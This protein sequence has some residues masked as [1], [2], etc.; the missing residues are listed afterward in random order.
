[1]V[2]EFFVKLES[3]YKYKLLLL[4]IPI[5]KLPEINSKELIRKLFSFG[6]E[7]TIRIKGGGEHTFIY[8]SIINNIQ[9]IYV[10]DNEIEKPNNNKL[11]LEGEDNVI[12]IKLDLSRIKSLDKLFQDC[13]DITEIDL[14]NFDS[15]SKIG[16]YHIFYKCTSL[17]SI[18]LNNFNTSSIT[19][20][21]GIFEDCINLKSLNLSNFDTSRVSLMIKMLSGCNNL[22]SLN[23]SNFNFSEVTSTYDLFKDCN[24]ITTLDLTNITIADYTPLSCVGFPKLKYLIF[25]NSCIQNYEKCKVFFQNIPNDIIICTNDINE[26]I[27]KMKL[28]NKCIIN[29]CGDDWENIKK[30]ISNGNE[31]CSFGFRE[32]L[33]E[34]DGRCYKNTI[35]S[36]IAN[37]ANIDE[38]NKIEETN[39]KIIS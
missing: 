38:T 14:S 17:T 4:I 15:S 22:I 29:Y 7:I 1:M 31:G 32:G 13:G 8:E 39:I 35:D 34:I 26:V 25:K 12:K 28:S 19:N 21:E 23:L 18:N 33:K 24:N 37:I 10:N 27:T 30:N 5:S 6:N 16:M 20:M 36:T 3:L 2:F 11:L 9:S